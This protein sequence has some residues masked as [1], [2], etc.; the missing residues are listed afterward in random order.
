VE[1]DCRLRPSPLLASLP[2]TQPPPGSA[3]GTL[4]PALPQLIGTAGEYVQDAVT[5]AWREATPFR[6]DAALLSHQAACPF[7]AFASYRLR[8][9][10]LETP[11][12]GLSPAAL[13]TL[14]H[15]MME[16]FWNALHERRALF[17]TGGEELRQEIER[18]VAEAVGHTARRYPGTLKPRLRQLEEE[19]L[20][21]L[22]QSWLGAEQERGDFTVLHTEYECEWRHERLLLRIRID[23]VDRDAGGE[24]VLV[25]YKSGKAP[26][27][28]WEEP[29]QDEPQL[30]LYLQALEQS[31]RHREPVAA[32]LY[33]RIHVQEPGYSGISAGPGIC[34]GTEFSS[35]SK[36]ESA[37]WQELKDRWQS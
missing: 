4:H 20:A 12:P 36:L 13:G 1:E 9:R 19:R 3:C 16:L 8:A 18:C 14:L 27:P 5:V 37:H 30:L 25:D 29:R 7:R 24:L 10:P 23:R 28:R 32:L 22:L 11:C 34:A 26:K 21:M 17:A 31:G 33:A 2:A 35:N 15:R 6:G